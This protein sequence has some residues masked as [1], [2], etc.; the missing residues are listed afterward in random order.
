[1][2]R[3][4]QR[5]ADAALKVLLALLDD[6]DHRL[7]IPEVIQ[8]IEDPE[9]IHAVFAGALHK[10]FGQ[11]IG[12]VA[13]THQVLASKQHREGGLLDVFLQSADAFPWIFTQEAMH[14]VEC[15]SAPDFH[16]IETHLV[17]VLSDG[18]KVLGSSARGEKR[19]MAIAKSQVLYLHR[20]SHRHRFIKQSSNQHAMLSLLHP[21]SPSS[22][23]P[24]S[25]QA[26]LKVLCVGM[27][28]LPR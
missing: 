12:I 20:I 10:G 6:L 25:A 15:G 13:I 7:E 22:R 9:N 3:F 14:G 8:S 17:H 24:S 4:G 21:E 26:M 19:L 11:V 5:I 16:G 27:P 28:Y 18:Q 23:C 1:M 2:R